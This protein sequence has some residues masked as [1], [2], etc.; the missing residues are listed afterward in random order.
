M[1]RIQQ[2]FPTLAENI[3]NNLEDKNLLKYKDSSKCN[4]HFLKNEKFYWVRILKKYHKYFEANEKSWKKA[5]YKTPTEVVQNL[6]L[7]VVNFFNT[8]SEEF[9][10]DNFC[11]NEEQLPQLTPSIIA[12][13]DGDLKLFEE[14]NQKTSDHHQALA[15]TSPIHLA[16]YRGNLAICKLLFNSTG[17]KNPKGSYGATTLQYAAC[18]GSLEVF[19][20]IYDSS[21]GSSDTMPF[22]LA[23]E[24]GHLEICKFIMERNEDKNPANYDGETPLHFAAQYGHLHVCHILIDNGIDKNP[25]DNRGVTP[26]HLAALHGH[27]DVCKFIMNNVINKTPR[28]YDGSTPFSAAAKGG[29][30]AICKYILDNIND[31]NPKD[32]DGQTELHRAA[33]YGYLE[34]CKLLFDYLDDKN[35]AQIDG[36]TPLHMAA[37]SGYENICK[38]FFANINNVEPMNSM[39]QTPKDV[40]EARNH[41]H[42]SKLFEVEIFAKSSKLT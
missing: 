42:I 17:N 36:N 28:A 21:K 15:D 32:I 27:M 35:P 2:R 12:A 34:V 25:D 3:L 13:Y 8:E 40:A 39:N 19:Q 41:I 29:H 7:A 1:D 37:D 31:K 11:L 16:A 5:I 9:I 26:L 6:A 30:L 24:K 18:S 4:Y 38:L 14:I 22:H 10:K 33:W 20:L 23:A